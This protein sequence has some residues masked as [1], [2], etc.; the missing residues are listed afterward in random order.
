M[1]N[2]WNYLTVEMKPSIWGTQKAEVLQE[3]LNKRG[4]E[5]WELVNIIVTHW[6]SPVLLVFK[7][8]A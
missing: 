7:K 5:G 4:R 6:A 2:R 8:E 3:E 1:N